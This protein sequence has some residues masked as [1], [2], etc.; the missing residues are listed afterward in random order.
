MKYRK[1]ELLPV[2]ARY[3]NIIVFKAYANIKADIEKT[4]LGCLWWILEP[5]LQT[6]IFFVVFTHILMIRTEK[7]V[8]FLFVGM[9]IY[10]YFSKALNQGSAALVDNAPLMRQIYL[11]KPMFVFVMLGNLTWKF[12]F[13]LVILFPLVWFGG[14]TVTWSY[15][16][17][18]LLLFLQIWLAAG[19]VL[20]LAAMIPYFPDGQTVLITVTS[21]GMWVSGVFYT[22]DKVPEHLRGWF[23][24]NPVAVLIEAY[25]SILLYGQWPDWSHFGNLILMGAVCW[26]LGLA[27]M[28]RID[29]R[30]TKLNL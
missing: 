20:P 12:L 11:P 7:F 13:S 10:N 17:L 22:V 9:T 24:L 18:P 23:Y 27:M 28:R 26:A 30:V 21:V 29:R 14:G 5:L 19:L 25:R 6:A 4:Y 3:T 2:L 1:K 16:A 8:V 15:L